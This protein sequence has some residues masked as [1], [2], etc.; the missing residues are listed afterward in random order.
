MNP[1]SLKS[2]GS[3]IFQQ[4]KRL[5]EAFE[6]LSVS[7]KGLLVRQADILK[8]CDGS[9]AALVGEIPVMPQ[10]ANEEGVMIG[11]G[12]WQH[13]ADNLVRDYPPSEIDQIIAALGIEPVGHV[14]GV[15]HVDS[16]RPNWEHEESELVQCF[17]AFDSNH[18]GVLEAKEVVLLRDR[19]TQK[20]L[21]QNKIVT[22]DHA[23]GKNGKSKPFTRREFLGS[24]AVMGPEYDEDIETLIS[25]LKAHIDF[26]RGEMS[27]EEMLSIGTSFKN[28]C[29]G[30]PHTHTI[31]M[32]HFEPRPNQVPMMGAPVV[33]KTKAPHSKRVGD[34]YIEVSGV[35][36]AVKDDGCYAILLP[37]YSELACPRNDVVVYISWEELMI[38][39]KKTK[40]ADPVEFQRRLERL[41]RRSA[42][43]N[44]D[45]CD[46]STLPD[47]NELPPGGAVLNRADAV[48]QKG[49]GA[50]PCRAQ[51]TGCS[52]M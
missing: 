31:L 16:A 7:K 8:R 41:S 28:L 29:V 5:D 35:F 24:L 6:Q 13:W 1:E 45:E 17:D 27:N 30:T 32:S 10:V 20:F 39:A 19:D 48:G 25:D 22:L 18:D 34:R 33:C 2:T 12:D 37:D 23:A 3:M 46:G 15:R 26:V 51:C 36:K 44:D 47:V 4:R 42:N 49:R 14:D 40:T 43:S 38:L 11:K 9:L 21:T 50:N 52:V